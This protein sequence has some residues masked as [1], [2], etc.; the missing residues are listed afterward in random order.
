[1][2]EIDLKGDSM[3]LEL[4]VFQ[5][6]KEIYSMKYELSF[7]DYSM[8]AALMT[9]VKFGEF[10]E[11]EELDFSKTNEFIPLKVWN[12]KSSAYWNEKIT[13]FLEIITEDIDKIY[14]LNEQEKGENCSKWSPES[15]KNIALF[16]TINSMK[17]YNAYGS[18]MFWATLHK[19]ESEKYF[20]EIKTWPDF[21]WVFIKFDCIQFLGHNNKILKVLYYSEI[22]EYF[23]YPMSFALILK[24]EMGKIRLNTKNS[25]EI[26]QM[27]YEYQKYSYLLESLSI[28]Y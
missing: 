18:R 4:V 3:K 28:K 14:N 12:C 16:T 2:E 11:T 8:I 25:F 24:N 26:Y 1:M 20:K 10:I 6:F 23:S 27:I 22:Q 9:Y 19:R 5:I 7:K 17:K 15:K 21:I 13:M